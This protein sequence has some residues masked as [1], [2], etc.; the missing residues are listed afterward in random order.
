M[1]L[2]D[3]AMRLL[4]T[5]DVVTMLSTEHWDPDR[6]WSAHGHVP[7]P[8]GNARQGRRAAASAYI[9]MHL[10]CRTVR[11]SMLR[12]EE[13]RRTPALLNIEQGDIIGYIRDPLG[14]PRER[15]GLLLR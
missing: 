4:E 14:L 5:G 7:A 8:D 1:Q 11:L 2:P 6:T 10:A 9:H 15:I 12:L 3:R 13:A